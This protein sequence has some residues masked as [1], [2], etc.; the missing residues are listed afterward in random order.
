MLWKIFAKPE[1]APDGLSCVLNSFH[2]NDGNVAFHRTVI[3]FFD[4]TLVHSI[5]N[6]NAVDNLSKTGVGFRWVI[7]VRL[8]T[9]SVVLGVV[10][11][12]NVKVG[13]A[14]ASCVSHGVLFVR[15]GRRV[16]LKQDRMK[17]GVLES[18]NL[19]FSSLALGAQEVGRRTSL[20][21]VAGVAME[22][23][24]VVELAV[25]L[26]QKP[27]HGMG[28]LVEGG[29]FEGDVATV[30]D[31]FVA[32]EADEDLDVVGLGSKLFDHGFLGQQL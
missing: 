20:Y 19:I 18:S 26:F 30:R 28:H 23:S 7:V 13:S 1:S 25:D 29:Q 10:L 24:T 27:V 16:L 17:T 31:S 32:V 14:W 9:W 12:R 11:C 2:V 8:T 6:V 22:R 21:D 15:K 3:S 5:D 4:R